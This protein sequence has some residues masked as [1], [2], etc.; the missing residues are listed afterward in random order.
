MPRLELM[1][2]RVVLAAAAACAV[3]TALVA[4]AL[5]W[6]FE[7]AAILSPVVAMV[8]GGVG[9]L[10]VLWTRVVLDSLRRRRG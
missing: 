5:D 6:S 1:R 10:A 3:L 8:A 9:F 4:W 7:R 2:L